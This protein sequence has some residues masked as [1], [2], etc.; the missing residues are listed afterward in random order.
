MKVLDHLDFAQ[1][2]IQNAVLHLLASAPSSPVPGQ[3]YYNTTT[4]TFEYRNASAWVNPLARA[5]HTGT[6]LAA[7][8]SDF[9]TQVR[10]SRLNQMAAPTSAVAMN[11]QAITG[12]ADPT[13]AQDAATKAYVDAGMSAAANVATIK[14]AVRAAVSTNVTISA[15]G[16]SLDGLTPA[17]G[18]VFLLVGQTTGTQNGP[19]VYNGSAVAMTR[20]GNWSSTSN[21]V[22]GSYWIVREGS[23]A[24]RFALLTNDTFTL[25]TDTAAV[26]YTVTGTAPSAGNGITIVNSVVAV[27]SAVVVSKY[28]A[29]I[30]DGSATSITVTHGLGTRDVTVSVR[31][32]STHA[33]V[34]VDWTATSTSQV[35]FTFAVAPASNAYRVVVHG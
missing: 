15:P 4:G 16:T 14:G 1:N 18:D 24:D 8:I 5:S 32:A 23:K 13:N 20:A 12:L 30:G 31:D 33:G 6:Q 3:A 11:G 22:V 9:D 17:N 19:Y 26:M 21:A 10:T 29:T 28:A 34:M 27:D 7:T 35:T 25:G 2:Q